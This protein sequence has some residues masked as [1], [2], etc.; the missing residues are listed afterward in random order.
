M[1]VVQSEIIARRAGSRAQKL[2]RIGRVY[3]S[4]DHSESTRRFQDAVNIVLIQ[5]AFSSASSLLKTEKMTISRFTETKLLI[6]RLLSERQ[7]GAIQELTKRLDATGRIENAP[8]FL[9]AV[10]EREMEMTTFV[11]GVAVPHVRGRAVKQLSVAI[12]LSAAGIPWGREKRRVAHAVFLFAIPLIEAATYLSLLSGLSSLIQDEI[13]FTALRQ[14]MQPEE[15]LAVLNS[16]RLVRVA[17]R[18]VPPGR[19]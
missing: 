12:G 1:L 10:L 18:P 8:A 19:A 5:P 17:V 11:E 7:D 9:E 6:P 2:H 16:V 15:M 14:A 4:A 3:C 13:A